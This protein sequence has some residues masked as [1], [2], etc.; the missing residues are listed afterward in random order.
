VRKQSEVHDTGP[1]WVFRGRGEGRATGR[2]LDSSV[3]KRPSHKDQE[4]GSEEGGGM[5]G[6]AVT[7][8]PLVVT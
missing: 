6:R 4:A 7:D 2:S 3:R 8:H 5:E 1:T